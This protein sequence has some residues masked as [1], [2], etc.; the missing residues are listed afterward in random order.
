MS[1]RD[2]VEN[3]DWLTTIEAA[4]LAYV[5]PSRVRDWARRGLL[6]PV[7]NDHNGRPRYLAAHVLHVEA[8]T[9]RRKTC[10]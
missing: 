10:A 2:T 1:W 6:T 5:Q 7:W 3:D 4:E 8:A 9:R